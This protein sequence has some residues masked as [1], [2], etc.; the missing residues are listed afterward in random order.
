MTQSLLLWT[1]GS[2]SNPALPRHRDKTVTKNAC[3]VSHGM[4]HWLSPNDLPDM[5]CCLPL[6]PLCLA[7]SLCSAWAWRSSGSGLEM[8]NCF[9][10][11]ADPIRAVFQSFSELPARSVDL[12]ALNLTELVNGMLRRALKGKHSFKY[13]VYM[14]FSCTGLS[15]SLSMTWAEH[16]IH[17]DHSVS[18]FRMEST[19]SYLTHGNHEYITTRWEVWEHHVQGCHLQS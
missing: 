16:I 6:S 1:R 10:C 5:N 3:C 19:L 13:H 4:R 7:F 17:L 15:S 9:C 8:R 12:S 18:M 14:D 11:R 2:L